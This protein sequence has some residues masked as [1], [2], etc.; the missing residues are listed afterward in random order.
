MQTLAVW[1]QKYN[2]EETRRQKLNNTLRKDS[3][4]KAAEAKKK[5]NKKNLFIRNAILHRVNTP[6]NTQVI[7]FEAP[8]H[9]S[10]TIELSRGGAPQH[11]NFNP[12]SSTIRLLP[13]ERRHTLQPNVKLS[14]QQSCY[15]FQFIFGKL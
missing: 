14:S 5:T 11:F 12:S 13:L 4:V 7:S 3:V 15:N 10:R 9:F 1:L 6:L 8:Q 2:P